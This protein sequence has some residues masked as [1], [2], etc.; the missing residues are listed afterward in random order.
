MT[1][2]PSPPERKI[3]SSQREDNYDHREDNVHGEDSVHSVE[4]DLDFDNFNS[5]ESSPPPPD[6]THPSLWPISSVLRWL[7]AIPPLRTTQTLSLC[8]SNKIVGKD[9][10]NLSVERICE[11]LGV[12]FGPH[13]RVLKREIMSLRGVDT[14]AAENNDYADVASTKSI[15]PTERV[16]RVCKNERL[17][18]V[19]VRLSEDARQSDGRQEEEELSIASG[20]NDDD[21]V[22]KNPRRAKVFSRGAARHLNPSFAP[23]LLKLGESVDSGESDDHSEGERRVIGKERPSKLRIEMD[24]DYDSFNDLT[25]QSSTEVNGAIN[26]VDVIS[27]DRV[28]VERERGER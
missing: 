8:V 6:E 28:E 16:A 13:K 1:P 21:S 7:R 24:S 26:K 9:L 23:P 27:N 19:G 4:T 2:S 14:E 18:S 11:L 5:N 12:A 17:S 22:L 10:L 20:L 3:Q 15:S 25:P